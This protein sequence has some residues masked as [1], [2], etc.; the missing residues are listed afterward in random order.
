M[1]NQKQFIDYFEVKGIAKFR[2]KIHKA[3]R[4]LTFPGLDFPYCVPDKE[5]NYL[6]FPLDAFEN[7]KEGNRILSVLLLDKEKDIYFHSDVFGMFL[8]SWLLLGKLKI[9]SINEWDG[10][11][12]ENILTKGSRNPINLVDISP[13]IFLLDGSI[14]IKFD[15]SSHLVII[16]FSNKIEQMNSEIR[17]SKDE[18]VDYFIKKD[19]A[20]ESEAEDFKEAYLK[21]YYSVS[22]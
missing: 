1:G 7:T 18:V 19:A 12:S 15:R 5:Y 22:I 3:Y 8:T 10:V 4:N 2:N 11:F 13:T 6:Y 17:L 16:G 20:D 14:L 9:K 21:N